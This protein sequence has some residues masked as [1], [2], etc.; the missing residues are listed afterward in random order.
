[1]KPTICL[2]I[3]AKQGATVLPLY[4]KCIDNLI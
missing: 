4:L 2:A 3:I 1:M